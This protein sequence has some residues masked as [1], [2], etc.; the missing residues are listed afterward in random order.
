MMVEKRDEMLSRRSK[1]LRWREKGGNYANTFRR[2][3]LASE[4]TKEFGGK[5][6]DE[7]VQ[8]NFE[9]SVAG[10]LVLQRNMGK[11]SF[12]SLL[13]MSGQIQCYLTRDALGDLAYQEFLDLWDLGDIVGVQAVSYTHLTLPTKRIV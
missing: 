1:M 13:D 6:K 2:G 5:N 10:R 4:L 3:G 8:L 12:I 7:L 11:A 9:T